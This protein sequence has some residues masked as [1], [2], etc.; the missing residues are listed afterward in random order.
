[1]HYKKVIFQLILFLGVSVTDLLAQFPTDFSNRTTSDTTKFERKEHEESV[2]GPNTTHFVLEKDVKYNLPKYYSLDTLPD[3]F[4]RFNFVDRNNY[5]MQDLGNMGTAIRPIF[6]EIPKVIGQ[7][8]GFYVYD[9]YFRDPDEIKYFD[10]KSP[11][12]SIRIVFGGEGRSLVEVPYSRNINPNWN[13]GFDVTAI[14]TDKQINS[15]GEGDRNVVSYAYDFYTRF[16]TKDQ[17]YQ[18]LANFSRLSHRVVES[19]GIVPPEIDPSSNLFGYNTDAKIWLQNAQSEQVLQSY[20]IYHQYK[21]SDKIQFYHTL[22]RSNSLHRFTDTE[23][24]SESS[25]FDQFLISTS[26]TQDKSKFRVFEN[27]VGFKGDVEN[28]FYSFYVKRRSVKFI[29]KYLDPIGFNHEDYGGFNIRYK[30]LD[31]TNFKFA[32]EYLLGG[33]YRVSASLEHQ[34]FGVSAASAKYLPSFLSQQY[35]GNHY[36]WNN[37]F[38]SSLANQLKAFLKFDLGTLSLR[39]NVALSTVDKHIYFN[40]QKLPEQASGSASII[41]PGLDIHYNF[42]K[43]L[44]LKTNFVYTKL[45]GNA[46][47]KFRIPEIFVNT[48]FYYENNLFK[49]VMLAQFG[50]DI[51]WQ[52]NYFAMDYDPITQQFFLQDTFEVSSYPLIDLYMS[53]KVKRFR[54]FLKMTNVGQGL[55]ADG[56]FTTPYYT[57]QPR[58]F[59]FG[60]NWLFFD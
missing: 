25:F 44:H 53:F 50:L 16:R 33:N 4:Q 52:S 40:Q 38:S 42:L 2:Y 45:S 7:T 30:L 15:S 59:D 54:G 6:Y 55:T 26:E 27:E 20:H 5:M 51:H 19:G 13:I 8:S 17:K 31:S 48:K 60:I 56:Y 9:L 10:T 34:K 47:D 37:N 35:F 21:F 14:N 18:L 49:K 29:H 32:G 23:L 12:S 39:P 41:S 22:D 36:E 58:T 11:F 46:A 24:S 1:M 43:N 3:N 28:I 57:G